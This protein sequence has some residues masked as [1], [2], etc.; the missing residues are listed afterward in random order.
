MGLDKPR[1]AHLAPSLVGT[2]PPPVAPCRFP[3]YIR[4]IQGLR[5][6]LMP[7]S[8]ARCR[9]NG[10][11]N[12]RATQRSGRCAGRDGGRRHYAPGGPTTSAPRPG[13]GQLGPPSR[14]VRGAPAACYARTLSCAYLSLSPPYLGGC[15]GLWRRDTVPSASSG[16]SRHMA[17]RGAGFLSPPYPC[18][19]LPILPFEA[20]RYAPSS[21]VRHY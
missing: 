1:S 5:G 7:P 13:C 3:Q 4:E 10:R 12:G 6:P 14:G 8:V 19:S 15:G 11:A 9:R 16:T 20:R 18:L 17:A 2:R 21:A